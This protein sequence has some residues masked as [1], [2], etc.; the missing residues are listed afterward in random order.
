MDNKFLI[1]SSIVVAGV[2]IASAIIYIK[3]PSAPVQDN[4]GKGAILTQNANEILSVKKNDFVL[5]NPS[6][7][8]AIVEYGDFQCP[9]CG[10]FFQTTEHEIINNYV[11]SG[12]AVFVWRD[13]AFLGPESFR[14]AEAARCAGEQDKFWEYHDYLFTHQGGEN[15]GVFSDANLKSFAGK[16]GLN[17]SSFNSCF[18]SQKY[19]KAVEASSEEGKSVGVNGTPATFIN[20]KLISGAQ[21]YDVFKQAIEEKLK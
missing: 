20:G 6:A 5:G 14:S 12:K 11:K 10:R 16:I 3:V 19:K 2:I 9:F 13:F 8:V 4:S 7:K 15:E 18:D 21:P 17:T 1:P